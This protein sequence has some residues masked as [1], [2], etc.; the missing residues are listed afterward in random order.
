[1]ASMSGVW[2]RKTVGMGVRRRDKWRE[3]IR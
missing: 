3:R 2:V 1:L